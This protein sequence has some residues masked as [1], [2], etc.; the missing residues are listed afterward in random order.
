MPISSNRFPLLQQTLEIPTHIAREIRHF[1]RSLCGTKNTSDELIEPPTNSDMNNNFQELT[2]SL[3]T[4]HTPHASYLN[5]AHPSQITSVDL[6]RYT[7][8]EEKC[9]L[10]TQAARIRRNLD[11]GYRTPKD[12]LLEEA[13]EIFFNRRKALQRDAADY[14]ANIQLTTRPSSILNFVEKVIDLESEAALIQELYDTAEGVVIGEVHAAIAS[15]Y[16]LMNHMKELKA[17][18]VTTLYLEHLLLDLQASDLKRYFASPTNKMPEQL[19][20]YLKNLDEGQ[21]TDAD[22][23]YTFLNLVKTAHSEG[24]Q[25]LALDCAASYYQQGIERSSVGETRQQMMNYLA[26]SVIE[27]YQAKH[28]G[29][30]IALVGNSHMNQYGHTAGLAELTNTIGLHIVDSELEASI[31]IT[32]D[33]GI[34]LD[35][36]S[37]DNPEEHAV[38]RGDVLLKIDTK[39][40]NTNQQ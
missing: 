37:A 7:I 20:K 35:I 27:Q 30:W 9:A 11:P 18:G 8:P 15:K 23:L 31:E 6:Q 5:L 16:F 14:F 12:P 28:T 29:K 38:L 17:Q 21:L 4:I 36:W 24:L 25:V 3:R 22:E 32:P 2:G 13:R 39:N 33:P 10:V 19:R 26:Q 1:A 34:E 40:L